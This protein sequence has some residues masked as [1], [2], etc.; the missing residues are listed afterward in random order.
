MQS[1]RLPSGIPTPTPQLKKIN[2]IQVPAGMTP[3]QRRSTIAKINN[4]KINKARN[5]TVADRVNARKSL[6]G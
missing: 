2:G 6:E 1:S 4:G 3:N 5:Q